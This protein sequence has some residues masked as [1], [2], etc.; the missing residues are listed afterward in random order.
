MNLD[1]STSDINV[2]PSP[3]GEKEGGRRESSKRSYQGN[4]DD[5]YTPKSP[6]HRNSGKNYS[7]DSFSL[8]FIERVTV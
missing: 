1:L 7:F 8:Q 5:L 4:T 6:I 3:P 2:S